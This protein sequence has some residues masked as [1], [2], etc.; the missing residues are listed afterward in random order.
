MG[1]NRSWM[2]K[3]REGKLFSETW[4]HGLENFLDHAFSL[5]EATV[6]GKSHC[7]C[8]KCVC[9][10]KR[11]RD[12]MTIHLCANGFQLGYE[13]WRHGLPFWWCKKLSRYAPISG[14]FSLKC[15]S[16]FSYCYRRVLDHIYISLKCRNAQ[17]VKTQDLLVLGN[18]HT[19]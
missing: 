10:H 2:Y 19:N 8:T 18:T 13:K 15:I 6:D 16:V 12:E 17:L 7:P 14:N 11:K 9:R 1:G 3:E 5:P 4:K